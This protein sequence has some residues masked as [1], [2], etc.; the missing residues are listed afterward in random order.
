MRRL[1]AVT[2]VGA[3]AALVGLALA[4]SGSGTLA[5]RAKP[6]QIRVIGEFTGLDPVDTGPPGE[7]AGDLFVFTEDLFR[8]GRNVGRSTGSC[9]LITPPASF[10]CQAIAELRKGS[11]TLT[12]NI[13]EGP[14][15][16]A[17]T[18]GTGKYRRAGGTFR[19]EPIDEGHERITYRVK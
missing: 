14:A 12:T 5:E 8:S 13:G 4:T 9:V 18:G 16:G 17:I 19:V 7:S 2:A 15:T 10:Q 1:A 6:K 3:T 11:L